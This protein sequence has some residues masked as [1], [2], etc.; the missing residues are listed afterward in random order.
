MEKPRMREKQL[1]TWNPFSGK[2]TCALFPPFWSESTR[3]IC[4][5]VSEHKHTTWLSHVTVSHEQ[6]WVIRQK[7]TDY[8]FINVNPNLYRPTE[9]VVVL[10]FW[11]ACGDDYVNALRVKVNPNPNRECVSHTEEFCMIIPS[12]SEAPLCGILST[13]VAKK[14]KG[15]KVRYTQTALCVGLLYAFVL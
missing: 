8:L 13:K 5:S 15:K 7:N 12:Q 3:C 2:L 11:L 6:Y 1:K 9:I 10:M 14:I 4:Q